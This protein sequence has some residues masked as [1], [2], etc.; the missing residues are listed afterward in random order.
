MS[1]SIR[2]LLV[3]LLLLVT[4][5]CRKPVAATLGQ[6]V[7]LHVR[8]AVHF[9]ESD[10]DLYFRRVVSDS[11][12]PTGAECVTAGEAVVALDGRILKGPVETFEV[13]LPAGAPDSVAW[14]AYDGYRIGLVKLEPSPSTDRAADTTAYVGTFLVEKR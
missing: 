7:L 12:C 5:S 10:L 14:R 3:A 4:A 1:P 13:R 6:P 2:T 11:R 9:Q 8:Q